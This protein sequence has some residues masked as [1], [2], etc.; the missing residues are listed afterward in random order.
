MCVEFSMD[1]LF[2]ATPNI[3]IKMI[4][5]MHKKIK[6]WLWKRFMKKVKGWTNFFSI[7]QNTL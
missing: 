3:I 5:Q 1:N 6:A 2:P 7:W 4:K